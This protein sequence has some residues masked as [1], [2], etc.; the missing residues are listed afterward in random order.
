M[1]LLIRIVRV[2]RE[3]PDKRNQRLLNDLVRIEVLKLRAHVRLHHRT[4]PRDK[5][6]PTCVLRAIGKVS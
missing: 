3:R 4:V 1:A 6:R 2:V 5:F